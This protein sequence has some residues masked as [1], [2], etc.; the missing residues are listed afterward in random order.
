MISENVQPDGR[1]E[2]IDQVLNHYRN[3]VKPSNTLAIELS[4]SGEL[5][6]SMSDQEINDLIIY[7]ET[8]TDYEFIS[9]PIF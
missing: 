6:I 1:F 5:G 9:N 8:L 3:G 4:N 7:L 2:T